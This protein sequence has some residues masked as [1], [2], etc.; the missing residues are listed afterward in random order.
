MTAA[1]PGRCCARCKTPYNCGD[2]VCV[3]H[4]P[5]RFITDAEM[6]F[7]TDPDLQAD[8]DARIARFLEGGG[9]SE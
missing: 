5:V 7:W 9:G 3:C 6:E 4:R 1:D 2:K 8:M